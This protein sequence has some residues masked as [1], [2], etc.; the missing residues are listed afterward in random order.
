MTQNKMFHI[1]RTN[2]QILIKTYTATS[3]YYTDISAKLQDNRVFF[4]AVIAEET[5]R[6]TSRV[7]NISRLFIKTQLTYRQLGS[8][9]SFYLAIMQTSD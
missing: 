9:I 4:V 5:D 7:Q 6:Q 8:Y 2:K 1:F 3:G